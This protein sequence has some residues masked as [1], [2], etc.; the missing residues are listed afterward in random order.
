MK[1]N[2]EYT[3]GLEAFQRGYRDCA[4]WSSTD[5][6]DMPMDGLYSADDI[7][8]ETLEKMRTECAAFVGANLA[9]L[10]DWNAAQAGHDFWLT[11]N[12]HGAGFWDRGRPTGEALS[13][14][15]RQA[16]DRYLYVGDDG[17]IY[18]G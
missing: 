11:R 3:G 4:L 13:G 17:R 8:P 7:A 5:N 18:Q 10:A 14:A 16:G 9:L 2:F 6:E 15:A 12:V 1:T